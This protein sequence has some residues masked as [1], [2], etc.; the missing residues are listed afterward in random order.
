MLQNTILM[1]EYVVPDN[2]LHLMLSSPCLHIL[3]HHSVVSVTSDIC[4]YQYGHPLHLSTS[5]TN[6]SAPVKIFW[7]LSYVAGNAKVNQ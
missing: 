2:R 6:D 3:E 5:K 7:N 4:N 1:V